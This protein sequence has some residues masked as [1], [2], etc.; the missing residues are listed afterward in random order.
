MS[1]R[2]RVS[3]LLAGNKLHCETTLV[4]VVILFHIR[5]HVNVCQKKREILL[6]IG[7]VAVAASESLKQREQSDPRTL[8]IRVSVM[9]LLIDKAHVIVCR[10]ACIS[11]VLVAANRTSIG[12]T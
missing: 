2:C 3:E 1:A 11:G 8:L 5:L 9:L 7:A 12:L 4:F 6:P 10:R